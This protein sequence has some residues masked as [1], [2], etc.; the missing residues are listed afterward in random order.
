MDNSF[1]NN[2]SL[3]IQGPFNEKSFKFLDSYQNEIIYSTWKNEKLNFD[4]IENERI[5]V[6]TK[7]LPDVK[8][9]YNVTNIYYQCK[10]I[11]NGLFKCSKPYVVK[12]RSDSFY[13][14]L[15]LLYQKSLDLDKIIYLP[16]SFRKSH[17]HLYHPSDHVFCYKREDMIKWF[18]SCIKRLE[19]PGSLYECNE[20]FIF[21]TFLRDLKKEFLLNTIEHSNEMLKKYCDIVTMSEVKP[22]IVCMNQLKLSDTGRY[23]FENDSSFQ[24][25]CIDVINSMNDL[26]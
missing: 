10:S 9:I 16:I 18:S 5:K 17:S 3:L 6:V 25:P 23:I 22:F 7:E 13:S 4:I 15:N 11:L 14:N 21:R 1:T 2:C 19:E 26:F 12:L 8:N 24:T 20:V